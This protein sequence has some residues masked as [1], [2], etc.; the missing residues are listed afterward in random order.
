MTIR[1]LLI[2]LLLSISIP[3]YAIDDVEQ[4]LDE[5]RPDLALDLLDARPIEDDANWQRLRGAA[6]VFLGR[7]EEGVEHLERALD[8][9]PDDARSHWSMLPGL[10]AQMN[11]TGAFGQLRLAR[12]LRRTME[13][14]VELDPDNPEY[15]YGL[16]QYYVG[17][18]GVAGGSQ[19][20]AEEQRD[21]LANIDPLWGAAADALLLLDDGDN[22]AGLE[23]LLTAWDGG[24]G[25]QEVGMS[26]V[27][28]AQNLERWDTARITAEQLLA[29]K[30]G[31]P[32]ALYQLGRTAALSGEHVDPALAAL[33]QYVDRPFI[34]S[35]HPSRAAAYW[36]K[37]QIHQHQGKPEDARKAWH[38]ALELDPGFD[39]ARESLSSLDEVDREGQS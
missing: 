28:N 19:R 24:D 13:A 6:L 22:E 17:A 12:Q 5:W 2:L 30:P 7:A 1:K 34:G 39:D 31:H 37:G 23:K 35:S 25:V 4:A 10:M 26:I 18:P 20:K 8:M 16:M 36:R 15:R 27:F 3:A 9:A 29:R 21:A 14:A 38:M 33:E 11:D 32:G